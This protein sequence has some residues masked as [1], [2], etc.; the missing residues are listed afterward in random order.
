MKLYDGG[1]SMSEMNIMRRYRF[2]KDCFKGRKSALPVPQ[3][4]VKDD[5]ALQRLHRE[6][7]VDIAGKPQPR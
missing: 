2:L 6:G 4:W 5:P 3:E 7:L 1:D